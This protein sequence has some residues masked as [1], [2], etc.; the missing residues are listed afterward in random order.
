MNVPRPGRQRLAPASRGRES[1]MLFHQRNKKAVAG[2]TLFVP[3]QLPLSPMHVFAIGI[4]HAL[5]V[6]V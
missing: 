6:E 1:K 2:T 5:D 3:F 4:E